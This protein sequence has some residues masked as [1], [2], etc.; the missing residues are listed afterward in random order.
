[1]DSETARWVQPPAQLRHKLVAVGL[2]PVS[3]DSELPQTLGPF[4]EHYFGTRAK[5]KPNTIRN[6]ATTKKLLLE[7]FGANEN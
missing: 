3:A 6:Y 5:L 7:Q 4:L 2:L 1:M